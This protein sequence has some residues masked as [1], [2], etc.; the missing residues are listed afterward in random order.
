M[1]S[2][3]ICSYKRSGTHLLMAYIYHNFNIGSGYE[4]I[5]RIK[6]Q[7]WS[8]TGTEEA[9]V[10]WAR[11]F[12]SHHPLNEI[13]KLNRKDILYIY[14]NPINC[15][16]SNWRFFGVGTFS[17]W[18]TVVNILN[19]KQHV[20]DY[21]RCCFS[22]RYEDLCN[23][24]IT[25]LKIIQKQFKLKRRQIEDWIKIKVPIGWTP[26]KKFTDHLIGD[27]ERQLIIE[28]LDPEFMEELGYA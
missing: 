2:L 12:G 22:I 19:W 14:R 17:D 3:R 24:P 5:M 7:Q 23:N 8:G 21:R 27:K 26:R 4:R 11:L 9:V 25:I 18:I 28:T 20:I 1:A 15:L 6:D 10:P 13:P 16:Y